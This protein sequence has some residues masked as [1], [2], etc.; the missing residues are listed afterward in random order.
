M[1]LRSEYEVASHSE[2]APGAVL[3]ALNARMIRFLGRFAMRFTAACWTLDLTS[4]EL[5]WA[6]AAHPPL[7]VVRDG[8]LVELETG[9]SF[10]GLAAEAE[11]PE[12][13]TTL[14]PGDLLVAY[15]DGL[16]E[17]LDGTGK[18]LGERR[19]Y[20]HIAAAA[21]EGQPVG[22]AALEAASAWAGR[23]QDDATLVVVRWRR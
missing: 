11:F 9:G 7:C 19:L 12:R 18:P 22:R 14:R 20:D 2:R 21:R 6:T 5:R 10:V 1:F 8:H 13:V 17:A 3:R 15:T 16:S 23:L 4:G